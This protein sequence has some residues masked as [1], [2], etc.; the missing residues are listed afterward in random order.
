MDHTV[1]RCNTMRAPLVAIELPRYNLGGIELLAA[2]LPLSYS[3]RAAD[4]VVV[5]EFVVRTTMLTTVDS[6]ILELQH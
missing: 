1:L 2:V 3:K 5:R 6:D 4:F